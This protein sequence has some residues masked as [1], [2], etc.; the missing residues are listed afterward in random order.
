MID[1]QMIDRWQTGSVSCLAM[2]DC[3]P[4]DCRP[5]GSSV[6]GISLTRILE[7]VA[8]PFSRGSSGPR[9][10]P[11]F[12]ALQMDSLL[13]E[14]PGNPFF[15]LSSVLFSGSVMSDS[16]QPHESQHAR[17]PYPS[18]TPGVHSNSCPLSQWCYL[19][20]LSSATSFSFC[21]QSFT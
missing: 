13:T 8:I 6:H 7:W 4:I 11:G 15:A 9:H 16:L 21:L 17:P 12:P 1:K 14:L 3:D 2:S 19:T 18:P 20:I 5:P 10:W